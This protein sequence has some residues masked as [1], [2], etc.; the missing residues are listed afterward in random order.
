M[1]SIYEKKVKEYGLDV[2]N[3]WKGDIR[4]MLEML[5]ESIIDD[6][7]ISF[8]EN[9]T[10]G[11]N[12]ILEIWKEGYKNRIGGIATLRSMECWIFLSKDFFM[13]AQNRLGLPDNMKKNYS[14]PHIKVSLETVWNSLCFLT[15]KED[16]MTERR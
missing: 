16:L 4:G 11:N 12:H 10:D 3:N 14:Q 9:K 8:L 7:D 13:A 5:F 1:E 2:P 15:M 6:T